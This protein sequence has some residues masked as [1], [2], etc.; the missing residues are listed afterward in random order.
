MNKKSQELASDLLMELIE[1]QTKR[2]ITYSKKKKKKIFTQLMLSS[3]QANLT[4]A[5]GP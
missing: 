4:S 1:I 2:I 3:C 5:R